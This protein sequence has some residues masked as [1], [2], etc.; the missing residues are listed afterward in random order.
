MPDLVEGAPGTPLALSSLNPL[1]VV[2]PLMRTTLPIACVCFTLISMPVRAQS[3]AELG[4]A[5]WR[6]ID[7]NPD[8]A[9]ALFSK[10]LALQP[11]DAA[12]H[13]GAGAAAYQRGR[14]TDATRALKSALALDP[15]LLVASKLLGEI[16]YKDGD[17]PLAIRTY[18][19]AL[20]HAPE[21]GELAGRLERLNGE[22]A[23]LESAADG[24][25]RIVVSFSGPSDDLLA[26]HA[27]EVLDS[28]YWRLAKLLG[29]FPAEPITV[30][31]NTTSPFR[32]SDGTPAWA[33]RE[34]AGRVTVPASGA[35]RDLDAFERVLAHELAHAMVSSMAPRGVPAW[36][37][38]GVAQYAE[39]ADT[40]PAEDRLQRA[41]GVPG[42]SAGPTSTAV[43]DRL[44]YDA[45][46]L[47][48]HALLARIGR[49]GTMVLDHLSAGRSMDEALAPFGFTLADLQADIVRQVSQAGR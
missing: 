31:L 16:A 25:E 18:E 15:S 29:A 44:S 42:L 40:Q 41:G 9:A 26:E 4:S 2:Y 37:Q 28:T 49:R 24:V 27:V 10:A 20:A 5:G 34:F 22:M 23:R 33:S 35:A 17:L 21:S 1:F 13:L 39:S 32:D 46:L 45:S 47:A 14:T 12:L 8:E 11:R 30:V 38:E 19:R 43:D 48:V 3:A 7:S 6:S 36:L